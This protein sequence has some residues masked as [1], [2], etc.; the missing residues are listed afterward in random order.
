[1]QPFESMKP[2]NA[3]PPGVIKDNAAFVSNV[4]DTAMPGNAQALVFVVSL[5]TID[6]DMA[7]LKVMQSD[8]K[9]NDTTLGGTPEEVVDI[10]DTITPGVGDDNGQIVVIIPLA[11][12]RKRYVQIQA[13]AGNGS[14]GTYLT[15]QAF[16]TNVGVPATDLDCLALIRV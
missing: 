9:T 12:P 1:M 2:V 13:T 7:A 3:I 4:I 11:G 8:T 5:G 14:A 10:T 6:A 15:A 16:F